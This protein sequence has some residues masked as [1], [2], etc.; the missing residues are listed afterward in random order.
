LQ[1][2]K[3]AKY[4]VFWFKLKNIADPEPIRSGI[5]WVDPESGSRKIIIIFLKK[6][7]RR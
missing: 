5:K 6:E 2:K 7:I 4:R 3:T 1:R